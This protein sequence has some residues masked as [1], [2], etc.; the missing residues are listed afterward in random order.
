MPGDPQGLNRYAYVQN[1]PLKYIDSCSETATFE[2]L[3]SLLESHGIRMMFLGL[4]EI[5]LMALGLLP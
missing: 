4:K 3:N 1:N 5:A 2:D